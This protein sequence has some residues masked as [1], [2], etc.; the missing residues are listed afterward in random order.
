M[1]HAWNTKPAE[2]KSQ[3][4]RSVA[5]RTLQV[6]NPDLHQL[7]FSGVFP[8]D[9]SPDIPT[10]NPRQKSFGVTQTSWNSALQPQVACP[11]ISLETGA[12]CRALRAGWTRCSPCASIRR[13]SRRSD[14]ARGHRSS[15]DG[16]LP[17]TNMEA[18]PQV[19]S[20]NG[21]NGGG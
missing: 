21:T 13:R 3:I 6:L 7:V 15:K 18:P 19:A 12:G 8:R 16:L 1:R 10:R 14:R 11:A 20:V 2:P 17:Q 4:P 5:L 9:S